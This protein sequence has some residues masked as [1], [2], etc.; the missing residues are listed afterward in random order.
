MRVLVL[1][2]FLTVCVFAVAAADTASPEA[3]KPPF[4]VDLSMTLP[5]SEEDSES[6]FILV[7]DLRK[8]PN[9][10]YFD[11]DLRMRMGDDPRTELRATFGFDTLRE[12]A[13]WYESS[14]VQD[15]VFSVHEKS[16]EAIN[17]SMRG[18]YLIEQ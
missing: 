5:V 8:L 9:L 4:H 6:A 14:S 3:E 11:F 10:V 7:D 13:D 12:V 2:L 17:L 1:S 18:K 16:D 15:F